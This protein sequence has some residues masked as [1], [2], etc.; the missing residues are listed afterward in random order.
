[1]FSTLLRLYSYVLLFPSF[2]VIIQ[3]NPLTTRLDVVP[4]S[5]LAFENDIESWHVTEK[6]YHALHAGDPPSV[7]A[8]ICTP[9]LGHSFICISMFVHPAERFSLM[10]THNFYL[11]I[12]HTNPTAITYLLLHYYL[13]YI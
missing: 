2:V 4:L 8:Y 6:A 11:F 5:L 9:F 10:C 1:M 3:S 7:R 13:R 12:T